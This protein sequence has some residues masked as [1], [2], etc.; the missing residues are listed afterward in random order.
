VAWSSG[1]RRVTSLAN[2]GRNFPEKI[3]HDRSGEVG[4]IRQVDV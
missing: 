3:S 1:A 4:V 2:Q